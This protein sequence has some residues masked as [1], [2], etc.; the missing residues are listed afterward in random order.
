[1]NDVNFGVDPA[2]LFANRFTID[3]H[4]ALINQDFT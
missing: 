3:A 4:A 1:M 2:S